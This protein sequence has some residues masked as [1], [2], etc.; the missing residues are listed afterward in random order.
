MVVGKIGKMEN[1][2]GF[3]SYFAV[4]LREKEKERTLY[5]CV[6]NYS[7]MYDEEAFKLLFAVTAVSESIC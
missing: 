6:K 7:I 4:L 5:K 1:R 3:S 2:K